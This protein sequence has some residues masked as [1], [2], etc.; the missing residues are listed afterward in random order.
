MES[1][2]S[3]V[4]ET[5]PIR[6]SVERI[7]LAK[8]IA[9]EMRVPAKYVIGLALRHFLS[10]EGW[11]DKLSDYEGKKRMPGK[12]R[13]T[14][15]WHSKKELSQLKAY[16]SR[17]KVNVSVAANLSMDA[18]AKFWPRREKGPHP[19]DAEVASVLERADVRECLDA[20]RAVEIDD[21]FV[22]SK[23][24][25]KCRNCGKGLKFSG[26]GPLE[27]AFAEMAF[28][29]VHSNRHQDGQA[30]A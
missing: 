27:R 5:L 15:V 30:K 22:I 10:A 23:S 29:S 13:V 24:K 9:R 20:A 17:R 25:I 26:Y 19:D 8:R 28:R 16:L 6:M 7:E 14:E 2:I 4:A 11:K 3:I 1:E 21:L 18:W 12:T